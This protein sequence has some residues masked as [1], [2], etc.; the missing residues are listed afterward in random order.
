MWAR[1]AAEEGAQGDDVAEKNNA[2]HETDTLGIADSGSDPTPVE[3][4]FT[5]TSELPDAGPS[6]NPASDSSTTLAPSL[7]STSGTPVIADDPYLYT[8][9]RNQS[10]ET[11]PVTTGVANSSTYNRPVIAHGSTHHPVGYTGARHGQGTIRLV[12]DAAPKNSGS[13]RQE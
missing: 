2:S 12:S 13:D 5:A 6:L 7:L 4:N 9:N 3:H 1:H 8:D 10:A 11:Q